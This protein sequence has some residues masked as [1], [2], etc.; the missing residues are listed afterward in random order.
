MIELSWAGQ[1]LVLLADKSIYWPAKRTL[2]F[3][4]VH[5]GKAHDFQRAGMPI[6]ARIHDDDLLR[7]EQLVIQLNAE[8]VL[9]LG[10]F[11]HSHRPEMVDLERKFAA[12]KIRLGAEWLLILGN[13]DVRSHKRLTQWA[14]DDVLT[15]FEDEGI[16]FAHDQATDWD[17]PTVIGHIHPVFKIPGRRHRLRLPCFVVREDKIVLPAFGAFTGGFE[18]PPARG[19]QIYVIAENSVVEFP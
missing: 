6:T 16:L 2:I 13:H 7:M 19:Q 18:I 3:S 8:R 10:D 5:L 14:F 15:A 4:D 1:D 9:V 17:G 11:V 12:L